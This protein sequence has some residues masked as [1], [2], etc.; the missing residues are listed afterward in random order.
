MDAKYGKMCEM[1]ESGDRKTPFTTCLLCGA[2]INIDMGAVYTEGKGWR[3]T[4]PEGCINALKSELA[5]VRAGRESFKM[6]PDD[7][8]ERLRRDNAELRA[9]IL[10]QRQL[11]ED[12][13]LA[14]SMAEMYTILSTIAPPD[15]PA[16][17][18][19]GTK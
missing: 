1:A 17:T 13:K 5:A 11:A 10:R 19:E 18:T 14:D 15:A 8:L 2:G 4:L 16:I 12:A 9:M 7:E 3:H 6:K